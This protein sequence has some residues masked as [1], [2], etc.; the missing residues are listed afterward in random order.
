MKH[1]DS[2]F[3][4]TTEE[5]VVPVCVVV[6]DDVTGDIFKWWTLNSPKNQRDFKS[7]MEKNKGD[8]FFSYASVAEGRFLLSVGLN[9]VDFNFVDGFLEYRCL[10]NHNDKLMFGEQLVDGKVKVTKRPPPKWQRSEQEAMNSFKPTHSLVECTYK[11]LGIQRDS[12]HKNKMRDILISGDVT[13]IENNRKEILDYCKEDTIFLPKIYVRMV[14]EYHNLIKSPHE[15]SLLMGEMILRGKY[16]LLTAKM[17]SRGYPINLEKTK[18][19]SS[20][21]LPLLD[22]CQ[23]EINELFPEIKPFKFDRKESKFS[24]DQKATKE[25]LTKNVDVDKWMKTDGF[26]KAVKILKK[27]ETL[28]KSKYLSL[29]LDAFTNVFD[30]KHDYPKDNFGAQMVRYLKLKQNMNGFVISPKKKSFL[31][32]VGRDGRVRPYFNIYGAQSSRSQP[33]ATGFLF[34]KPAWMR[35]LCEPKPGKAIASFDYASEEFLISALVS[36]DS[37]MIWAYESGD[38]Y[39]AFAKLAGAVPKDA[40]KKDYKEIRNLFKATT[41][42]VSYLMAAKGL[43]AKLS[44]DTGR[45]VSEEEAQNLIDLFYNSYPDFARWQEDQIETYRELKEPIKLPC[46]WKMWGDNDNFRSSVNCPIQGFGGSIMRKAVEFAEE[47]GLN[48][49][50]T[51]HDALYIEYDS[52]DFAAIDKLKKAMHDGFTHYFKDK[53]KASVIRLDGFSWSPDYPVPEVKLNDKGEEYKEYAAVTT[54]GGE[55]IEIANL[56]IDERSVSEYEQ[57]SKYFEDS[58]TKYL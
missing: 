21:V 39:F 42:G 51:L 22:E 18:N 1:I 2:E 10:T 54:P 55:E 32:F 20:A 26:K 35:V 9:P 53:K 13:L 31:D 47:A 49:I 27:G 48:V 4:D 56:Y 45:E 23:R 25:W 7:F 33:G 58:G 38:V 44:A 3:F 34:L 12:I 14:E 57:F 17:E 36:N 28:D 19:F 52:G 5:Q 15:R 24:W 50:L 43:A 46:G 11:L 8:T 29:S 41:L 16:A 30:F 6:Y 37:N 40:D